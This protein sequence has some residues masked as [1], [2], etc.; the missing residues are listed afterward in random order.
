MQGR[1]IGRL[2]L[3]IEFLTLAAANTLQITKPFVVGTTGHFQNFTHQLNR[4]SYRLV[5]L[6]KP[7]DQRPLLEMMF[8]AFFKMSRSVSASI[9]RFFRS[10]NSLASEV[11][12]WMPLPGKLSAPLS[13][14]S[15]RHRWIN[16]G[17]TPNSR[18]N[19]VMF[20]SSKLNLT[21]FSL[22]V[23]S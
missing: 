6:N 8:K 2:Y 22:N 20:V 11:C 4:P 9:S 15:L 23:Q 3:L 18:A 1:K 16:S 17:S 10:H 19:S 5:V 13:R 14:H 21:A 12:D 7:E